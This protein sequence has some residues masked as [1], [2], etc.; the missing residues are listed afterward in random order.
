MDRKKLGHIIGGSLIDGLLMRMTSGADIENAKA[1]RFVCIDGGTYRFFSLISNIALDS[2]GDNFT[3]TTLAT[4]NSFT[5]QILR[6][7]NFFATLF[8]K[9]LIMLDAKNNLMPV[10]TIPPHCAPVYEAHDSEIALIFG[11]ERPDNLFFNIGTPLDMNT[12]VCLDLNKLTERSNAVFGKTGTGKTFI[13]RILL[14]GILAKKAGVNLIFDMHSEYGLQARQEGNNKK[15]VKGL[16]T[17][18]PS[19]VAIF[20]LD[21]ASTRRRGC[22]PD[23]EVVIGFDEITVDDIMLLSEELSLHTT[24]L[25]AAYLLHT[26]FKKNWL[27]MLLKNESSIKEL[28]N[29]LGAHPESM[30]ALLRKLK[31]LEYLPFLTQETTE[32]SVIKSLLSYLDRGISVILEFG[33]QTSMLSYLL[34]TGVITRHIHHHYVKKTEQYLADPANQPEPHKLMITIEEAHKFLNPQAAKQTIFG[35][36]ARELRKYYVSLLIVDQRP[37]SIDSEVLS[38]VG[39]KLIAQL[40]DERDIQAVLTGAPD[41][42]SLKSVLATLDSKQQILALGH[43]LTMPIVLKT[44]KFDETFYKDVSEISLPGGT[45]LSTKEKIDTI[46]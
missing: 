32:K 35:T 38:Q 45:I 7:N 39:T 12:P 8:I 15:F 30:A 11:T 2:I 26:R 5:A 18:F 34:V 14:A 23:Q 31:R 1:G 40:N 4:E 29:D 21:P 9:P 19:Q 6:K 41:S 16:K 13:T 27:S 17:L 3:K 33:H 37:S 28:S 24:A 43:A 22:A 42:V 44:R 20:S 36:I 10:K 25:E 46:F